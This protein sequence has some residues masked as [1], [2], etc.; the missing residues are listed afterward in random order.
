MNLSEFIEKWGKTILETPLAT[1]S[2]ADDP[3]DEEF[4]AHLA[5]VFV[6]P[7]SHVVKFHNPILERDSASTVYVATKAADR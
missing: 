3:P 7:Q 2:H 1:Q 5:E 4:L 6:K